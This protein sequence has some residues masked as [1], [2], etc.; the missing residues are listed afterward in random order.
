MVSEDKEGYMALQPV[1]W[2]TP[3]EAECF[4]AEGSTVTCLS[5]WGAQNSHTWRGQSGCQHSADGD[6]GAWGVRQASRG[7]S[8]VQFGSQPLPWKGALAA[9]LQ[10]STPSGF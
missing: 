1:S 3:G 5:G 4:R 6:L 10:C 7:K 9:D 2:N 8:E